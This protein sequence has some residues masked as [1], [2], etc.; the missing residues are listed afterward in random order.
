MRKIGANLA[1]PCMNITHSIIL[2][3]EKISDLPLSSSPQL[4]SFFNPVDLK[5]V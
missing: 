5:D 3:A 4:F 1:W 2:R